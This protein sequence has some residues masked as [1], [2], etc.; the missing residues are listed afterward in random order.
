MKLNNSFSVD[1]SIFFN[2][3][4]NLRTSESNGNNIWFENKGKGNVFGFES[5]LK[6][7]YNNNLRTEI[8]YDYLTMKLKY[9]Q[10]SAELNTNFGISDSL[11]VNEG[12][13]PKQQ[14]KLKSFYNI[15]NNIEFDN[16][17]FYVDSL[18]NI[19]GTNN[20]GIPSYWRYD[21]RVGYLPSANLD[22]SF[23]VQNILNTKI[24]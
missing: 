23:G 9:N 19:N 12:S 14:I 1:N 8:S 13:S 20:K 4:K 21:A 15:T 11:F 22:L 16:F 17:L 3:Y 6:Y 5:V 2:Q 7:K 10:D 18:P 24:E